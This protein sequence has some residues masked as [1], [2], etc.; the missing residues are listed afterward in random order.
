MTAEN[1]SPPDSPNP[2]NQA[3]S[4]VVDHSVGPDSSNRAVGSLTKD[5]VVH[6]QTIHFSLIAICIALAAVVSSTNRSEV[7]QGRNELR[8]INESLRSWNRYG[9][10]LLA[11]HH[12]DEVNSK[13]RAAEPTSVFVTTPPNANVMLIDSKPGSQPDRVALRF[14][15]RNWMVEGS[16]RAYPS[17]LHRMLIGAENASTRFLDEAQ[18]FIWE[19]E[20]LSRF[21]TLW[22]DLAS[23][24]T[25]IVP[26]KLGT[27]L[28]RF[29]IPD[30][31]DGKAESLSLTERSFH[32]EVAATPPSD[33]TCSLQLA[34]TDPGDDAVNKIIASALGNPTP[35]VYVCL[36]LCQG[37]GDLTFI[38]ITEFHPIDFDAQQ[39]LLDPIHSQQLG[40]RIGTGSLIPHG[41]FDYSFSNLNEITRNY[42]Q[43]SLN[44]F[45][46]IL[47]SE[48]Q[49]AG[50][51]FEALGIKFP[52]EET[53]R[54]GLLIILAIQLYLW[55]MLHESAHGFRLGDNDSDAPWIGLYRSFPAKAVCFLTMV[56]VPASV[57]GLVGLRGGRLLGLA[58]VPVI[59]I[60]LVSVGVSSLLGMLAWN[61]LPSRTGG[62]EPKESF[63]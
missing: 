37:G 5:Y 35:Y 48:Q 62:C 19:P 63:K 17:N 34:R 32:L 4:C 16:V 49:R 58:W 8:L 24:Q 26:T 14:T 39:V 44:A 23:T 50:E 51:S 55:V 43:L 15:G 29:K 10:D 11:K 56:I 46:P 9:L 21:R 42:Q 54:W 47:E 25:I 6:L 12:L 41:T 27:K 22:D 13:R 31:W 18:I 7:S 30:H 33:R 38:P 45:G 3:E 52:A 36:E 61:N 60:G 28:R 1:S 20:T 59:L 40:G 53:T 57:C 2:N